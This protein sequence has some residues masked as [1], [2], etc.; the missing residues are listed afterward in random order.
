MWV[1]FFNSSLEAQ[2]YY[3]TCPGLSLS[4]SHLKLWLS[5]PGLPVTS[6]AHQTY[7]AVAG[8]MGYG[9]LDSWTYPSHR[10]MSYTLYLKAAKYEIQKP[11][12]CRATLF[13]CKFLSMFPVFHLAWWTWPAAKTFVAGWRNAARWLVDLLGHEQICCATSCEFNEKRNKAKMCCSK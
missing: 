13:R 11:S 4:F 2:H 6:T 1:Q 8:I 3:V 7:S 10:P 5:H 12:T 9:L